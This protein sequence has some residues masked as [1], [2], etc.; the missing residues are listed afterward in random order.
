M[1][2]SKANPIFTTTLKSVLFFILSLFVIYPLIKVFSLTNL[3]V[4]SGVFT[5]HRWMLA[6]Q[7]SLMMMVLSTVS[8]VGLGFLFAY[9]MNRVDFPGK[10]LFRFV[11]LLPIISPPFVMGMSYILL[12]GRQ[13]LISKLLN[14]NL[15][16][17][18]W[19][20]LWFVQTLTF[21][22]VSFSILY[23][24]LRQLNS[25]TEM[26]AYNMGATS[27][28]VFTDI[29]W[30]MI[31][32]AIYGSMLV[33]SMN[34]MADFGNP[35]VVGGD[36]VVLSTEAY[37]QMV[38]NF[39]LPAASALAI[40]LL[41]PAM[42]MFVVNQ[43]VLRK[44][45]VASVHGKESHQGHYP[46]PKGTQWTLFL[47]CLIVSVIILLVYFVLFAGAFTKLWGYDWSFDLGNMQKV[48]GRHTKEIVNTLIISFSS[49]LLSGSLACVLAL[50]L[51]QSKGPISR[52]I[53]F[54]TL[55]VGAIPG[56]FLG[57]GYA[58]AY[59]N[60]ILHFTG[61][62][63]IMILALAFWNLTVFYTTLKAALEQIGDNLTY[64]SR[65][66]G[67]KT[68]QTLHRVLLPVMSKSLI[69]GFTI[70]F[71]RSSNCLSVIV[72]IYSVNTSVLTNKIL[73]QVSTGK[74]GS[75]SALTVI[76]CVIDFL[77]LGLSRYLIHIFSRKR[78]GK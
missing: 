47:L 56:T 77:V 23:N 37:Q 71:L 1:H 57:L 64:A 4:F 68:W 2:P 27:G 76:L 9:T 70:A 13:G 61:S 49:A 73:A 51:K 7:H 3:D 62:Y 45:A 19:Q 55:M 5:N 38:G 40:L 42:V 67:A 36:F 35:A 46:L 41:T 69:S 24:T 15:D 29:T 52:F 59:N 11:T 12:L 30:P 8:A 22:P 48:L 18:G 26:A 78:K 39:N 20:G 58:M 16:I 44:G 50:I 10:T 65:N 60:Q 66:L 14:I 32:P 43:F 72:F 75:A 17:Y 21:F 74:W 25:G 33:T 6:L 54:L 34:V 53:E 28:R 31:R 63:M